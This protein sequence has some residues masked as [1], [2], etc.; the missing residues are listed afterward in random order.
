MK[1]EGGRMKKEISVE[2]KHSS[3]ILPPSSFRIHP[4]HFLYRSM[5]TGYKKFP[6]LAD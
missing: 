4:L 6:F 2:A 3:F 5:P 1:E